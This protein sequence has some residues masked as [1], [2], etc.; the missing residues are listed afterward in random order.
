MARTLADTDVIN[1]AAL[2]RLE[3]TPE[4]VDL[5]SRQLTDILAYADALQQIDT[6]GITPT[7]HAGSEAPVWREDDVVASIERQRVLAGA[8][9]A[10]VAAGLFKVPKVL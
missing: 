6:T 8:P 7:S 1:I 2:A 9:G 10:S 4:E 3:L 5:F